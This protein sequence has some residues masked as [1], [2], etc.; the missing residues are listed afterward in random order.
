MLKKPPRGSDNNGA[1]Q[2]M[3]R[4]DGR[5]HFITRFD[6]WHDPLAQAR[7]KPFVPRCGETPAGRIACILTY[8][9]M[10]YFFSYTLQRFTPMITLSVVPVYLTE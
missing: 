8:A 4:L 6:C 7:G 10:E 2:V 3:V 1:L 5:D 9:H